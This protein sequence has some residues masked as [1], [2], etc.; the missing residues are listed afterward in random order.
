MCLRSASVGSWS[1]TRR[2]T[3]LQDLGREAR[4]AR[5]E[6]LQRPH[7][8]TT[9]SHASSTLSGSR[10]E[11]CNHAKA[12]AHECHCF[13]ERSSGRHGKQRSG[14]RASKCF[15]QARYPQLSPW[16]ATASAR[17]WVE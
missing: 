5:L 3:A 2:E 17:S 14:A 7:L 8:C 13:C 15:T 6:V 11:C 1:K 9:A 12:E 10:R 4:D 16:R